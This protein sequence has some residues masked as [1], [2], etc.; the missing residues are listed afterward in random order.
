MNSSPNTQKSR[1]LTVVVLILLVAAVAVVWLYWGREPGG[2]GVASSTPKSSTT[3]RVAL[4]KSPA[5]DAAQ[6]LIPEFE[7]QTGIRVDLDI[8]P[9]AELQDV[10][11]TEFLA[12]SPRF[13]IVMADCI[14]IPKFADAGYLGEIDRYLRDPALTPK[15]YNYEDLIPSVADYLGKYPARGKTY[16]FPFMTN[17]H[18]LA[19]REDLYVKYLQPKGFRRPGTTPETAWTW[20][21]YLRAAEVLTMPNAKL[22][23]GT[24]WGSSMQAKAGAW[25]VYEWYSWLYGFGGK[26]IDYSI[27]RPM[28]DSPAS[29]DAIRQYASMVGKV[30]PRSVLSWGHEEETQALGSGLAA[31]DATWNVELTGYLLDPS[32]SPHAKDFKFGLSPVGRSGKPTPDMGGYGILLS[33]FSTHPQDAYRLMVWLTSPAVHRRIVLDG[34]TPFRYSEMKD[35]EILKKY[36][37]Y[38]IYG[39]ALENSVY[40][41]RVPQWPEIEDIISKELTPVMEGRSNPKEAGALMTKKI[42]PLLPKR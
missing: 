39:I 36:Q 18:V 38:S 23:G 1:A 30:A 8:L 22:P 9:Y 11:Q 10:V 16:G 26:D 32:T 5:V 7:A 25:L 41:A 2:G 31:M 28:F 35:P 3:L 14:W 29:V 15:D 42:E 37:V 40:R 20:D 21:E 33:K 4:F 34:G 13:D 27:M 12:R 24:Q 19:Y 6:K 17:S